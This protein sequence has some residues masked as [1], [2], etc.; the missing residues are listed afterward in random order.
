[1]RCTIFK[2]DWSLQLL[3]VLPRFEL[4]SLDSRSKVLTITPQ[5]QLVKNAFIK[6]ISV[7]F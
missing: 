7:E 3:K 1:M 5:N 2:M 4:G 6:T